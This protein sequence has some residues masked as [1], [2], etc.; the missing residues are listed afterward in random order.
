MMGTGKIPDGAMNLAAAEANVAPEATFKTSSA[1]DRAEG[2]VLAIHPG[3]T[4]T[5]FGFFARARNSRAT[6][7]GDYRVARISMLRA[8]ARA[9]VCCCSCGKIQKDCT[10]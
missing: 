1:A 6:F 4:S 5:N 10:G 8:T 9:S 3:T 7:S 2:R